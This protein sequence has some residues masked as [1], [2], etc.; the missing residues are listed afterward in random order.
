M[1]NIQ[2]LTVNAQAAT[3]A[4]DLALDLV[5]GNLKRLAVYF[6]QTSGSVISKYATGKL[7][8]H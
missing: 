4:A 8:A 1:L 6:D 2:S 3:L 7:F 5:T